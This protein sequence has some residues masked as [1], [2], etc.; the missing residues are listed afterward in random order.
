MS[1]M[2]AS[3]GFSGSC[4]CWSSPSDSSSLAIF[5]SSDSSFSIF[6]FLADDF[7]SQGEIIKICYP[8]NKLQTT[9]R[10]GSLKQNKHHF[11]SRLSS[12]YRKHGCN[13]QQCR[14]NSACCSPT[15]STSWSNTSRTSSLASLPSSSCCTMR[16]CSGHL[17]VWLP[18]FRAHN[19][20]CRRLGANL[21]YSLCSCDSY[22][23]MPW[24]VQVLLVQRGAKLSERTPHKSKQ[25]IRYV[26]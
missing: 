15:S 5:S 11:G 17:P 1:R 16:W 25:S 13:A 6:S 8:K 19:I 4:S 9:C 7:L 18:W 14:W 22:M 26:C 12:P 10:N 3:S 21:L 23:L 24:G 20:I 2:S